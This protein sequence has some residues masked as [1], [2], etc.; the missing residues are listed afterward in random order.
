MDTLAEPHDGHPKADS[1]SYLDPNVVQEVAEPKSDDVRPSSPTSDVLVADRDDP[2]SDP[3]S[4]PA[5][6]VRKLLK[7]K[8]DEWTAVI[9][10]KQGKL[11]LLELPLDVLRLIVA[12]VC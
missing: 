5:T 1:L 7:G 2:A 10:R 11:T 3:A 4:D 6:L 12:E 8:E 9:S